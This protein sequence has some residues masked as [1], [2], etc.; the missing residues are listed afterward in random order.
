MICPE[1]K[2][3]IPHPGH[4]PVCGWEDLI[5]QTERKFKEQ[6]GRPLRG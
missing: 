4:C 2:N 5:R 6:W 3:T 1:C